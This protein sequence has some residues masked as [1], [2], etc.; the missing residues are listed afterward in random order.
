[1]IDCAVRENGYKKNKGC[2]GNTYPDSLQFAVDH[3]ITAEHLYPYQGSQGQCKFGMSSVLQLKGF[4][5]LKESVDEVKYAVANEG[6]VAVGMWVYKP[7]L[8]YKTGIYDQ[9]GTPSEFDY[10][11]HFNM[12]ELYTSI[13]NIFP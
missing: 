1:M 10:L 2:D 12:G 4:R 3:G 6:P 7:F 13:D 9:C 8:F 11:M 5:R